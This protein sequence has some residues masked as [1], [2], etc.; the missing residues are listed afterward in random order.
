MED[1][2][3]AGGNAIATKASV[4]AAGLSEPQYWANPLSGQFAA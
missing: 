3:I 1:A 2:H 4:A